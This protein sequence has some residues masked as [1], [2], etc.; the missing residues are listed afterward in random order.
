MT[1]G[2][3]ETR[4]AEAGLRIVVFGE[5]LWDCYRDHQTLGGS[6]LNF[7][8]H[9]A[10]LGCRPALVSAVGEDSLGKTARARI[11]ELGVPD[12][13][14]DT[15]PLVATGRVS[16]EVDERGQPAFTIHRPAAYD[17]VKLSA[18]QLREL[19]DW[20]PAWL[21]YGTLSSM[22]QR[23]KEALLQLMEA[24]PNARRFYDVNLREASYTPELV[25]DLMARANVVK[26][27]ADEMRTI[28]SLDGLPCGCIEE[29]CRAGR[30]RYGW[31]TVAVT[32]GEHGCGLW[33]N[34]QYEEVAGY[35]VEVADTVGAGDAFAAAFVHGLSQGWG[36]REIGEFANKV[37]AIVASRPGGTPDWTVEEALGIIR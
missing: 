12:A 36:L 20:G 31:E 18:T 3:S 28:A 30:T 11:L 37:G 13:F 26:L 29:F 23:P 2:A 24:L 35:A 8:V 9:A 32:M 16:V 27:N 15:T 21:Y 10:R 4:R 34:N 17:A 25:S 33:M 5:V 7:A 19:S 1:P 14:L 22:A 6:P